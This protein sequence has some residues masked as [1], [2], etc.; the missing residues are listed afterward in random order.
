MLAE[1]EAGASGALRREIRR[2]LFHLKQHGIE[3]PAIEAPPAST[4]ASATSSSLTALL[5]PIDVEG[6][7][8]VWIVK[9]RIQGGVLRLWALISET[10]GLVGAQNTGLTRRELKSEREQLE[11]RARM[12]LIEA[13]YCLADFIIC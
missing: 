1:M 8:I 7:R 4:A 10:D 6:A 9:P 13:D 3:P 2:A 11:A 5:S 12:K